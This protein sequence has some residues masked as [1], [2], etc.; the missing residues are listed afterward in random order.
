MK[1]WIQVF[2]LIQI[3]TGLSSR[4]SSLEQRLD[5]L[6][7]TL[8]AREDTITRL[9]SQNGNTSRIQ[10]PQS[11]FSTTTHDTEMARNVSDI[12]RCG[13]RPVTTPSRLSQLTQ[14]SSSPPFGLTWVQADRALNMFRR[15]FTI[16]F[17]FVIIPEHMTAKELIKTKP[18]LC[19]AVI[20]VSAPLP[21]ARLDK[22]KR[23]VLAYLSQQIIVEDQRDVE[24]LQALLVVIAW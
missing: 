7:R 8:E 23:N 2:S 15:E 14:H 11:T 4:V 21:S 20:L 24:L 5:V 22:I 12:E 10:T 19:R 17:P 18:A 6:T 1:D 3:L 9:V 13:R 16:N